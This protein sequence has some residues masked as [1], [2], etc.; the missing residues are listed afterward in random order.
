MERKKAK[1]TFPFDRKT[2]ENIVHMNLANKS[3]QYKRTYVYI[4]A[5][6]GIVHFTQYP[7]YKQTRVVCRDI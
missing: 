2:V 4:C 6:Y 1:V 7:Y 5:Y 3:I